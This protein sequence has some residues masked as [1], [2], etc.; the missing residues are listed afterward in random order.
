MKKLHGKT[1]KSPIYGM[2]VTYNINDLEKDYKSMY[3]KLYPKYNKEVKKNNPTVNK[4][5]LPV[6]INIVN[7]NDSIDLNTSITKDDIEEIKKH[8]KIK[9]VPNKAAKNFDEGFSMVSENNGNTYKVIKTTKGH[10]RWK[11]IS[12]SVSI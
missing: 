1:E 2:K 5:I 10:K 6:D 9:R 7:S 11:K 12:Q 3:S 8:I 4:S